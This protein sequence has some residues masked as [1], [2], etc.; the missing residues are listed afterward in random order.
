MKRSLPMLIASGLIAWAGAASGQGTPQPPPDLPPLRLGDVPHFATEAEAKQGCA[1][2]DLVVWASPD[3]GLYYLKN[4]REYGHRQ[5]GFYSCLVA[6][7]AADYWDKNPFSSD[8]DDGRVFPI[9]P[10]LL[11]PG[12]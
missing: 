4:A 5:P 8:P 3:I 10:E 9:D 11:G 7:R 6:A 1:G 12:V 2:H